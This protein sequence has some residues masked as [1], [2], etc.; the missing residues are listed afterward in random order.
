MKKIPVDLSTFSKIINEGYL[1]VDKTQQ[2]FN[3]LK[4]GERYF[5]L[6]RPRR[7]GKTLLLSTLKALFSGEKELFKDLWIGKQADFNWQKHPVI[8]LD[9]SNADSE[10]AQELKLSLSEMLDEAAHEA[11]IKPSKSHSPKTKL[12][13]LVKELFKQNS[14]VILIDEY[15]K[16]ILDHIHNPK[17]ADMRRA[18]LKNFYDGFK[19][20]DGYM[21]AIFITGVSKFTKTSIFSGLNNLNELSNEPEAA[22]LVGH[23][24]EEV[25]SVFADYLH[26]CASE[27]NESPNQVL[28]KIRH[29]YNGYRFSS[30]PISIYNP[31]SIAFFLSVKNLGI[32]GLNQEHRLFSL[33]YLKINH[34]N[35]GK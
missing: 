6:S 16:P 28:E 7:F 10:T 20:L 18:V 33:S 8:H 30:E 3:L 14:V 1:Y 13:H 26:E 27:W 2:I 22:Q 29:W 4:G 21:R 11:N 23:T 25:T 35:S 17:K 31:Y 12:R 32:T 5:F 9:F 15:D 19:G 24:E 34:L